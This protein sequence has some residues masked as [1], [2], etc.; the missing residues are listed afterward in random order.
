MFY[1]AWGVNMLDSRTRD[2]TTEE[3]LLT[4]NDTGTIKSTTWS[5]CYNNEAERNMMS[6]S[7]EGWKVFRSFFNFS[8]K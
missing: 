2:H 4:M 6:D 8:R 1:A 5:R 7:K 3:L